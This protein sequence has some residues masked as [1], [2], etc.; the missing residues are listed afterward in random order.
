[1]RKFLDRSRPVGRWP[2]SEAVAAERASSI[3]KNHALT[4]ATA[5][6]AAVVV[7]VTVWD[8]GVPQ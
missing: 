2:C 3:I 6:T 1:M 7:F 8:I 5:K 4:L